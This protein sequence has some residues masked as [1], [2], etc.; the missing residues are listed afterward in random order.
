ML[1]G[2]SRANV[3]LFSPQ[4]LLQSRRRYT[5]RCLMIRPRSYESTN[6][7]TAGSGDRFGL[8][9]TFK[10]GRYSQH[11]KQHFYFCFA[12]ARI[13]NA[14][15]PALHLSNHVRQRCSWLVVLLKRPENDEIQVPKNV[16]RFVC[17]FV[18]LL[19]LSQTEGQWSK[20]GIISPQTEDMQMCLNWLI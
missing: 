10:P 4:L 9:D 6:R 14:V 3:L 11:Q 16:Q 20:F 19:I 17:F 7:K 18:F 2:Q 8:A 15:K 1:W 13:A 12:F 5:K